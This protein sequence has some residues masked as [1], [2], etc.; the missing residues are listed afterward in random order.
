MEQQVNDFVIFIGR[1]H[2]LLVHLPI[3]FLILGFVLHLLRN[4][5]QFKNAGNIIDLTLLLGGGS[6]LVA[7]VMGYMLS[8]GGGYDEGAIMWHQW[9]GILL[10]LLSFAL[11]A[12]RRMA[13]SN[14]QVQQ[15]A[16]V[17]IMVFLTFTGHFGGNLTHGSTYLFQYAPN[18]VRVMAGLPPKVKKEYKKITNV[19]SA[20]VF[21]D[22]LMP[23][24]D[25]KC[26]SC[27]NEEKLK[28]DLLLTSFEHMVKGGENGPSIV[29]GDREKSE[30]YRRITLAHSHEEFMPPEGKTPLS[31][32]Q[33][34]MIGWW[35]DQG[36]KPGT[37]LASLGGGA[38]IKDKIEKYLGIGKYMSI[39][40]QPI[41]PI[42]PEV[43][44]EIE[45]AGFRVA[46]IAEKVNYLD[47]TAP[48]GK[49][50]EVKQMEVLKKAKK[51]I[52]W[53]DLK[54]SG[55]TDEHLKPVN[56]LTNLTKLRLDHND[57][58]D[59][60]I[61]YLTDLNELEYINL[62]FTQITD[63]ALA[64]IDKLKNLDRAYFYQTNIEGSDKVN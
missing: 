29:A 47:V 32:E 20:L 27:H 40:N 3:G 7:C 50:I 2:P 25:A 4:V 41:D 38:Q 44:A 51:H 35:I 23:M 34:D 17:L 13:I 16:F 26:I 58:S 56:E 62:S 6:G 9:A 42:D 61:N 54:N 19:D 15:V 64:S 59:K 57:I 46:T 8:L 10:T 48:I 31:K 36:A 63:Q 5:D 33:V 45:A 30:L 53:L 49:K 22:I 14:Q 24:I 18:P 37:S 11:L 21:E 60:G 28:G 43:I 52:V 1:F 12:I 39:L 55:L